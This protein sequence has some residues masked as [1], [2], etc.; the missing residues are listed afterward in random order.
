MIRVAATITYGVSVVAAIAA[1]LLILPAMMFSDA[2]GS[3][4][5][6]AALF[7]CGIGS[8]AAVIFSGKAITQNNPHFLASALFT[9]LIL[10][11]M[12]WGVSGAP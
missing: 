9:L 4:S 1:G 12:L 7:I 2:P 6:V 3:G 10:A 11:I 5:I 8:G